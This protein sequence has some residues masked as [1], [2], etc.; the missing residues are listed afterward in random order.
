QDTDA[1]ATPAVA[2]VSTLDQPWEA[3]GWSLGAA[4]AARGTTW[5]DRP[6]FTGTPTVVWCVE[7]ADRGTAAGAW[8]QIGNEQ[9]LP[10]EDWQGGPA[11][12]FA[13]EDAVRLP[14]ACPGG[15]LAVAPSP[16]VPRPGRRG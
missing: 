1:P 12:W 11:A 5:V 3:G 14:P 7:N 2:T 8:I 6:Y 9:N 16:R 13:F 10:I 4:A 15:W